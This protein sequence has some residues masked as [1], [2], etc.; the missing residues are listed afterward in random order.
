MP[1][2]FLEEDQDSCVMYRP[3]PGGRLS[4]HEVGGG[5]PRGQLHSVELHEVGGWDPRLRREKSSYND[6]LKIF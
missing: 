2:K 4:H 3:D 1:N 6:T 5:A